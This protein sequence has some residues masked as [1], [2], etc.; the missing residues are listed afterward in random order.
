MIFGVYFRKHQ[1][2]NIDIY[3][4][5]FFENAR[6]PELVCPSIQVFDLRS[7]FSLPALK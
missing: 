5:I 7:K 1:F 3:I 4:G 2:L 6:I